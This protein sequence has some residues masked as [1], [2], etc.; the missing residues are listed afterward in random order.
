[1]SVGNIGTMPTHEVY[2][3]MRPIICS[4]NTSLGESSGFFLTNKVVLTVAHNV[5][6]NQLDFVQINYKEPNGMNYTI[7][8]KIKSIDYNPENAKATDLFAFAIDNVRQVLPRLPNHVKLYEGMN[9]YFAGFPLGNDKITFHQG[10][11]SSLSNDQGIEEF[12]I[13]GTVVPGNSGGPVVAIHED[14][15]YLIGVITAEVSDFSPE[16]LKTI[17]IM[18]QLKLIHDDKKS[19]VSTDSM[20]INSVMGLG[21]PIEFETSEGKQKEM[22]YDKQVMDLIFDLIQ[23]NLSTGIGRAVDIREYEKLISE[24][25]VKKTTGPYYFPTKGK[26]PIMGSMIMKET[27]KEILKYMEIRYGVGKGP[28]GIKIVMSDKSGVYE[29]K[30]LENPHT[31]PGN[32]NKNQKEL[33]DFAAKFVASEYI[34]SSTIPPKFSFKACQS[35]YNAEQVF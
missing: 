9:V 29:Y 20:V 28:R 11:I 3:L 16:D 10:S 6:F 2:N 18:K 14:Q 24:T 31:V 27:Q 34:K 17:Q 4:I 21:V 23:K 30:F 33:Y 1:M 26:K 5:P 13:D 12:T 25:P 19:T 22:I 15:L 35:K 7:A 32:Y 8:N